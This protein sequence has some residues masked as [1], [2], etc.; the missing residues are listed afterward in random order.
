MTRQKFLAAPLSALVLTGCVNLAPDYERPVA[1]VPT[2][3]PLAQPAADGV[4][5]LGWQDIVQSEDLRALI[6]LSLEQNRDLRT[7][8]ATVDVARAN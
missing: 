5:T 8:A 3:L 7:V 1:P 6:K 4:S 2:E